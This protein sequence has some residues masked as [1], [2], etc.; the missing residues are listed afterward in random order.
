MI[1]EWADFEEIRDVYSVF[2]LK[3]NFLE[4]GNAALR[5]LN[6]QATMKEHVI[7]ISCLTRPLYSE[8]DLDWMRDNG[9]NE[10]DLE[11]AAQLQMQAVALIR[12]GENPAEG[13]RC[14]ELDCTMFGPD[15]DEEID[16]D[17]EVSKEDVD[18][19]RKAIEKF[20][21]AAVDV[22]E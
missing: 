7:R 4:A 21:D 11:L 17:L 9:W 20:L 22:G 3:A 19:A 15:K 18:I 6:M 13:I 16:A 10:E 2:P 8:T 12:T 1:M 14:A 5:E